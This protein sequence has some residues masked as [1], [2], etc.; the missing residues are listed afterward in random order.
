M[1]WVMFQRS[2]YAS[3]A[4]YKTGK[5]ACFIASDMEAEVTPDMDLRRQVRKV[6]Y[7]RV[8]N[9]PLAFGLFVAC[10]A[11]DQLGNVKGR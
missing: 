8:R 7:K 1:Q 10:D 2:E 9:I 4:Q 6:I 5:P 11:D 3:F